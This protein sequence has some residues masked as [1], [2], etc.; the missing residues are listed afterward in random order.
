MRSGFISH[1]DSALHGLEDYL[2]N[3]SQNAF[4]VFAGKLQDVT[5]G[6]RG[7]L[8]TMG[9]NLANLTTDKQGITTVY[10]QNASVID[11]YFEYVDLV[12]MSKKLEVDEVVSDT[13][14][15]SLIKN[16]SLLLVGIA[17]GVAAQR[18]F[19]PKK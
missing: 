5:S 12:A 19:K 15:S 7:Q 8:A 4:K 10:Q 18:M 6:R 9:L 14:S 13:V 17:I 2:Q 11:D 3:T 16:G 1:T